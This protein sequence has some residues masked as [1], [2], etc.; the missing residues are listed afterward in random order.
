ME[1][2]LLSGKDSAC[3]DALLLRGAF[4]RGRV[5]Q[6]VLSNASTQHDREL[7]VAGAREFSFLSKGDAV[8][9]TLPALEGCRRADEA[10]A[11]DGVGAGRS[12]GRGLLSPARGHEERS[13]TPRNV[14]ER[15]AGGHPD[16]VRLS[17]SDVV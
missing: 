15:I 10:D 7:E 9:H 16:S 3:R 2:Q 17:P 4:A 5:E 1:R 14:P 13:R 6:H 12:F 8:D 11:G